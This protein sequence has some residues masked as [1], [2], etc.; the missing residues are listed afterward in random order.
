[1]DWASMVRVGRVTR[2]WG[3]RGE[4]TVAPDTD[5]GDTRFSAGAE[6]F[7]Q[8]ADEIVPVT[9]AE[10]REQRGWWVVR[11]SGVDSID[12]AETFRGAELRVPAD[13]LQPLES[14]RFYVHDLLGCD[15]RRI[16]GSRVGR[17][18]RVDLATGVPQ[19]AVDAGGEEILVPLVDA[20]CRRIDVTEKVIEIDP[21]E[22]LIELNRKR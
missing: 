20:I 17:V 18:E 5:F 16:D 6:I 9:V 14:G 10:G 1:M 8:R 3:N 22:G 13:T 21:P 12:A 7:V 2:P 11:F 4:V 15:V 19:L